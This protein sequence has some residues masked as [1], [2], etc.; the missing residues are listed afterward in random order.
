MVLLVFLRREHRYDDALA[1]ATALAPR[2]PRNYLLP[3]E[4]GNLL[5]ASGKLAE[6]EE[7]YRRVWQTGREGKYGSLHYEL[8]GVALGDVLRAEK[9]Y[10]AARAYEQVGEVT[11]A[12]PELLQKANLGAGEMYDQIEKRDFALKK[13]QAVLAVDSGNA[14]ADRARQRMKQAYR[15]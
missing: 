2:F 14:F 6:A 13:Y 3:I 15:E 4:Q 11:G 5:R 1:I 8:A 10:A 12:D 9:N 7:Q